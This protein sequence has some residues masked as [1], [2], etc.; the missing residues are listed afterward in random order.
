MNAYKYTLYTPLY[1]QLFIGKYAESV[2]AQNIQLQTAY[3][4][5]ILKYTPVP[6][7]TNPNPK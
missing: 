1:E 4:I 7:N 2:S 6:T 3:F 5:Q